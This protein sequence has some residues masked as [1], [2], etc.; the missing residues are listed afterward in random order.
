MTTH[1]LLQRLAA[2]PHRAAFLPGLFAALL[3]LAAWSSELLLRQHGASLHRELSPLQ[4]HAALM[5]YGL[6]PFFMTGFILTAAPRWLNAASPA[7][8]RCVL[9]PLLLC[10]ALLCALTALP[11][12]HYWL[13]AAALLWLAALSLLAQTM[14]QLLSQSTV[15]DRLHAQAVLAALLAGCGGLLAM[16]Y[17]LLADVATA[18]WWMRN[19]ALWGFLLP[20]FLAVSHRMLPF[21]TQSVIAPYQVWRPRWLLLALVGGSW[22]YGALAIA[23]LPL[24]PA[25][26][27]LC[28]LSATCLYRWQSWRSRSVPLL[29]MLHLAF[30]WLPLAF[31]LLTLADFG[32][33]SSLTGLH[34]VTVGFF[35][36]MLVGFASRVML[37]HAGHPLQASRGLWWLYLLLHGVALLRVSADLLPAFALRG[38]VLAALSLLVGLLGWAWFGLPLLAKKRADGKPG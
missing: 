33:V 34:A 5:L 18:W 21:F 26:L 30:A 10:A 9:I 31:L 37:G 13:A 20:V 12:S 35:I 7:R 29:A 23:Q 28:G 17:W 27:L 4:A 15:T 1:P 14:Q 22:L 6:F 25:S 38:Y 32:L 2:T 8:W 19:L 11:G 36:T 24:W 3:L 16:L